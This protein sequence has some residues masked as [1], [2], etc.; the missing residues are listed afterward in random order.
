M[1]RGSSGPLS[2]I[3]LGAIQC[4][5]ARMGP[6]AAQRLIPQHL[7]RF[8]AGAPLQHRGSHSVSPSRPRPPVAVILYALPLR[9]L[10]SVSLGYPQGLCLP[11]DTDTGAGASPPSTAA[12]LCASPGPKE[13][14]SGPTV[15][16]RS[17]PAARM[18]GSGA[19][20]GGP[21]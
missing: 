8:L 13:I 7:S 10:C 6:T 18:D 17:T 20:G 5:G 4:I 11:P 2:Y 12:N 14:L 9:P 1:S 16:R 15:V 19:T 21:S 3:L